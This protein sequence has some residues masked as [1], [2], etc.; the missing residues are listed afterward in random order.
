M[1]NAADSSGS[2]GAAL[3]VLLLTGPRKDK[4]ATIKWDN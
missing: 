2:Y 4:V 1:W 3:K